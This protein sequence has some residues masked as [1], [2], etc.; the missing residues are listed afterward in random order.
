[1]YESMPKSNNASTAGINIKQLIPLLMIVVPILGYWSYCNFLKPISPYY[2]DYDPEFQYFLNSLAILRGGSYTYIDHPGTPLE[3]IG[4]IILLATRIFLQNHQG[5]FTLYHLQHPELF[6]EL[7]RGLIVVLSLACATFFFYTAKASERLEDV[8]AAASLAMMFFVIHPDSF[9]T[10]TTWS[11]NSFNFAFGTLLLMI[12]FRVFRRNTEIFL[13][14]IVGLGLGIG[15]LTSITVYFAAWMAGAL[16]ALM[17]LYRSLKLSWRKAVIAGATLIAASVTGFVLATL[18]VLNLY[19]S[20]AN[21]MTSLIFHQGIYGEGA[22]GI[23]SPS[24]MLRNFLTL[25]QDLPVFFAVAA[26]EFILFIYGLIRWRKEACKNPGTWAM[27][28]GLTFMLA[29]VIIAVSK[30]PGDIY[31]LAG[32]AILPVLMTIILDIFQNDPALNHIMKQI[33]AALLLGGLAISFSA[34]I[35]HRNNY[36]DSIQSAQTQTWQA[37][38]SYGVSMSQSPENLSIYWTYGTYSP[39]QSLQFGDNGTSPEIT[40]DIKTICGHQRGISIWANRVKVFQ[41]KWDILVTRTGFME[42]YPFLKEI[43]SVYKVLP[44]TTDKFGSIVIISN[45]K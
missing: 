18:P 10:L 14:K 17:I 3:I 13:G 8:F 21:W 37:I 33:T 29:L 31:M 26:L 16:A 25:V 28:G 24:L 6:L 30:H 36:A 5:S 23:T 35:I 42:T 27:A 9:S 20:F 34:S 45:T 40:N 15:V 7:A 1:M 43:G 44:D 12:Q 38:Q 22:A 2:Q 4:T 32:A 39:C 11:H 41:K 19:S